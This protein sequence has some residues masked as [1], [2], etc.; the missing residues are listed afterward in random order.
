M[1]S[2]L[3]QPPVNAFPSEPDQEGGLR[4]GRFVAALRRQALLIIGITTVTA[5]AAVLKAV[6]DTPTYQA[7]FELLT[8]PETLETE[9]ISA[10][11]PDSLSGRSD[12]VSAAVDETQLKILMS[13]R[14]MTPIVEE[15]KQVYPNI[16][17]GEVKGGLQV[18]P[19]ATGDSVTV[20]YQ[21]ENPEKVNDVLETVA[22]AYLRYSLEDR[23][24]DISR[25]IDFLDEQLPTL[26]AQVEQLASELEN[27]RQSS[28]LIDPLV[29]GEQ[30]S[31]QMAR[32]EAQQLELR[33]QIEQ[34]QQLYQNLQQELSAGAELGASSALLQ[35]DR[36]QSLLNQLIEAD[37]ELAQQLTLYLE[38]SPEVEVIGERRENLQP[39]LAREGVRVQEQVASRIREMEDQDRA[40]SEAIQT[41]NQRINQLST[42]TRQYNDIQRE[43]EIA[44]QNLNQFL[45]KRETLRIDAAQRQTPWEILTPPSEPR[46]SA[47]SAK[48]NLALGT[49]LGLMLGS[50]IAILVDR[51]S[52]K[53]YTIDELKEASRIP[54]L[55]TIPHDQL[56]EKGQSLVFQLNQLPSMSDLGM[57]VDLYSSS[58]QVSSGQEMSTPLLEAF[59]SLSTNVRLSRPNKPIKFFAVSSAAPNAGKSTI[60]SHLAHAMASMGQRTLLVD[61]DLRRPSLH[62]LCGFSNPSKGLSSYIAGEFELDEILIQLPANKNLFM[63]PAGPVPPNPIEILTAR[64]MD[65]FLS[66]AYEDFDIVIFD[67]PPLLGFADALTIASK[68]QGILLTA[69]LGQIKISQLQSALDELQIARIPVVGMVANDVQEEG[70]ESYSYINY[71]QKE[72]VHNL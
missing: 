23:K 35:S 70:I 5:S 56:L 68:A 14:V 41:L 1:T 66:R 58:A 25:G 36:Y 38:D 29:Q 63:V 26:R 33:V 65:D 44:T 45:T 67:T 42:V 17:Y 60:S 30:L 59:R 8:P 9:I 71:Y 39:L 3:H 69:R 7:G 21:S 13:P 18:K 52:G 27:L 15:L 24:S 47:A 12:I 6:T 20:T 61:T 10:T 53:I 32:F 34:T 50:G 11:L 51:L 43:L 22:A 48:R 57:D 2:E 31:Q 54:I 4:L 72:A 28:N 49:V 64:R 37:S 19:E 55:G 46:A 62:R 16:T 40:L